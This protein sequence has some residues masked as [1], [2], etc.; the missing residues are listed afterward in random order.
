M[1][2]VSFKE[3]N[4]SFYI[5]EGSTLLEAKEKNPNI[6]LKFGCKRGSCGVCQIKILSGNENLTKQCRNEASCLK[7]KGLDDNYRLACQVAVN[8]NVLID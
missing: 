7:Q 1:P 4:C 5:H 6:P 8:G 2:T 3:K